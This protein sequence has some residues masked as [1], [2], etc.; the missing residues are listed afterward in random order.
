MK[1][2]RWHW[3]WLAVVL[4]FPACLNAAE[5]KKAPEKKEAAPKAAELQELTKNLPEPGKVVPLS[6]E[7]VGTVKRAY[8]RDPLKNYKEDQPVNLRLSEAVI[9]KSRDKTEKPLLHAM[10]SRKNGITMAEAPSF[11]EKLPTVKELAAFETMEPMRK[12]F[13]PQHGFTDGWG[14]PEGMHWT[15]QWAWFTFDSPAKIRLLSV[16]AHVHGQRGKATKIDI[17]EIR[18]GIFQPADAKSVEEREQFKTGE[19]LDA[20][21]EVARLKDLKKYPQPLREFLEAD[22]RPGDSDMLVMS[23]ALNAQREKPDGRLIA[24]LVER[25]EEDSVKFGQLLEHLFIDDFLKLKAW[26]P[27]RKAEAQRALVRAMGKLKSPLALEDAL[28]LLLK[29]LGGGNVDFRV[30]GLDAQV[31]VAVALK[32]DEVSVTTDSEGVTKENLPLVVMALQRHLAGKFA[33][34]RT[35]E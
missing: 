3:R 14:G 8:L 7:W 19:E 15:E 13:G 20:R 24:Q 18:E 5:K 12:L 30:P 23:Q 21:E 32:K 17:I 9:W 28:E 26:Q 16:F 34:L 2:P 6:T 11:I 25:L 4:L 22:S 29:S 27:D 1:S 35:K 33:P 10:P 31:K